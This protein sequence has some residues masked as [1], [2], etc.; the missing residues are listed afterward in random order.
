MNCSSN[1]N[2]VP[3]DMI[4]LLDE[5]ELEHAARCSYQYL[6]KSISKD[7]SE[8]PTKE[9]RDRLAMDMAKRFLISESGNKK[10]ALARMKKTIIFRKDMNIDGIRLCYSDLSDNNLEY[11]ALRSAIDREFETPVW[12][13]RGQDMQNR[14]PVSAIIAEKKDGRFHPENYL[15]VHL[16]VMEKAL[17]CGERL[18]GGRGDYQYVVYSDCRYFILSLAPPIGLTKRMTHTLNDHYPEAL[19]R[20]YLVD[21]PAIFRI[22]WNLVKP[23]ID[24]KIKA[25]VVFVTG[26]VSFI[27]RNIFTL[28][29]VSLTKNP[30]SCVS[31]IQE[32]RKE[33]FSGLIKADQTMPFT[34]PDGK[35]ISKFDA[36]K[37]LYE[38]PF[39]HLYEE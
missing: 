36:R 12:Q 10:K 39:D 18:S 23:F 24:P 20:F 2:V 22:F 38:I 16:Y 1:K 28:S 33:I 21:S 30:L 11:K 3:Q 5:E 29:N 15:K 32:Q 26:E 9:L 17:A 19:H 6:L 8:R 34:L 25:K 31:N 4:Q 27:W 35:K 37:A 14:A 7:E 13:F